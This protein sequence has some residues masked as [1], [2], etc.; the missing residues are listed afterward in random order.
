MKV[1]LIYPPDFNMITTNLPEIIDEETG[2]YP[3]LGLMYIA[4]CAKKY[5]DYEI[6]ILDAQIQMEKL[7]YDDLEREIGERR[8]DVVGIQTMT[9]TLIDVV[10]TIERIK[11][12]DPQI[13]ICLGGPHVN[14]YPEETIRLSG[15]DS[16][17]L[18]EGEY[19]FVELL[20]A[21][22]TQSDISQVK[23]LVFQK[24]KEI[25]NTG[26]RGLIDDL[27][28]LPFPVRDLLPYKKYYSVLG[29]HTPI[30]TMM[31]SRGCPYRC[32]FCDRPHLGKTFRAR[33]S[34]SVVDEM[35]ECIE[36]GIKEIFM[37]DD[38]FSINKQRVLDICDEIMRRDL[39]IIWDIRARIDTIDAQ[40][41]K[42]LYKAGCR[43]IH[44][45]VESGNPEI[46][47]VLRKGIDLRE[48]EKTFKMTRDYGITTLAYF[49]IGNPAETK[50]QI[51]ETFAFAKKIKPD[52]VHFAVTT[53]FPATDLYRLGLQ[54]G[55]LKSDYWQEFASNPRKDF[56]PKLWEENLLEK[57]LKKLLNDM[58]KR[59]YLRPGYIFKEIRRIR[60]RQEF[61]RK[62]KAGLSL[63]RLNH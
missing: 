32:L 57:E 19:T 50:K 54:K 42:N 63:L 39:K 41:L 24:G 16:I 45:G 5:T 55:I 40:I 62:I 14:I 1:L 12:I 23:G 17:V 4:A 38:T 11:K 7:D 51:M 36:L 31:T 58:Y 44:Y 27:D 59:F 46:L 60:S 30:T 25:I 10:L 2:C 49:M 13:H 22:E 56:I 29:K 47:R 37:Y 28:A 21:L 20:R 43:R 18:G 8:P 61:R 48:A 35:E 6:E 33:S 34:K 15:V 26:K 9:F 52:Y 53:P 3:P